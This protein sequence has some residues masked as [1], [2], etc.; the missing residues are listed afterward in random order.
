LRDLGFSVPDGLV[1]HGGFG[2]CAGTI[3]PANARKTSKDFME[4][5]FN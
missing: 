4:E 1:A 3:A 2:T 5:P